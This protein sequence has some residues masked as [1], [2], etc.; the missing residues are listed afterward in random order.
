MA[1]TKPNQILSCVQTDTLIFYAEKQTWKCTNRHTHTPVH[2]PVHL[3]IHLY[4]YMCIYVHT[5]TY[6]PVR[7]AFI[8][9][10]ELMN[11]WIYIDSAWQLNCSLHCGLCWQ[12]IAI[13]LLHWCLSLSLCLYVLSLALYTSLSLSLLC[14][15]NLFAAQS[16]QFDAI[17]LKDCELMRGRGI[18]KRR[19]REQKERKKERERRKGKMRV[20]RDCLLSAYAYKCSQM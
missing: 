2:T 1:Q 17:G 4:T 19:E 6:T 5:P 16:Q 12:Y 9:G 20:D 18:E 10:F 8:S 14:C 3:Y 11:K 15:C 13:S 7:R